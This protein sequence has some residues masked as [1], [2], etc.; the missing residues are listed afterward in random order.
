MKVGILTFHRAINYGAVWQAYALKKHIEELGHEA[1][2]IDYWPDYHARNFW[3]LPRLNPKVHFSG[4]RGFIDYLYKWFNLTL[5]LKRILRKRRGFH[6][7][8]RNYLNLGEHV[9]YTSGAELGTIHYDAI[10]LGSD[11]IWRYWKTDKFKGFDP[12]YFGDFDWHGPKISY[13]ASMGVIEGLIENAN[14]ISKLWSNFE[15]LSVREKSLC[16]AVEQYAQITPQL[17]LDPVFLLEKEQWERICQEKY[18]QKHGSEFILFYHLMQ[19]KDAKRI[20]DGLAEKRG[21]PVYEVHG[22]IV[23]KRMGR[24]YLYSTASPDELL[25]L[26]K[27]ATLIVS[28]SFHGVA[29]SIIFEK[30]FY[31]LGMGQKADRAKTLLHTLGLEDRYIEGGVEEVE[32]KDINWELVL[33]KKEKEIE[34][35]REF[36]IK[37]LR[38]SEKNS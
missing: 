11:Q 9:K 10:V 3:L 17:V 31:A 16:D 7:Y 18:K 19:S 27:K 12:V 35:S 33:S 4:V 38:R 32:K 8:F 2:I 15:C 36:L 20:V 30:E 5:G 14:Q 26:F 23:A 13:A 34:C 22:H 24:R 25:D 37:A 28:S 1:E 6:D 21:L 29:M